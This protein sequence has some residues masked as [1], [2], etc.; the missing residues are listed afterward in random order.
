MHRA[1]ILSNQLSQCY[2]LRLLLEIAN[3]I[4]ERIIAI[5]AMV[6]LFVIVQKEKAIQYNWLI[7]RY[8]RN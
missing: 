5:G 2:A 3:F 7:L 4:P 8:W 1:A 6:K